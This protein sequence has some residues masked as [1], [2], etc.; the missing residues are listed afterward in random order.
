MSYLVLARK[1]RPQNFEDVSGQSHITRTLQN[2]IRAGRIAHAYLFTGVRGVGKTTAARI[3]AKAL[4]CAQGPTPTPCNECVQCKEIIRGN[5]IDV[6]EID[7]ASNRGI[8]EVRQIIENVRYQPAR[9]SFKIYII[10]EVHQVTKDAFNALLKTLEE[11]PASVKFILATT[12]PHRLPETILSRCQRFDF[13]RISLKEIVQR[14]SDISAS[15]GLKISQEALIAVAREADGSMRD[16]QSLL[17]QV[18]SCFGTEQEATEVDE[19]LLQ[20]VLGLAE[21]RMLF[22]IS[23]S[24]IAGDGRRCLELLAHA[25]EQGRDLTRLS[26]DLV[27]HFRNLMVARLCGQKKPNNVADQERA[28][29]LDLPDQEVIALGSQAANVS[30]DTLLDYFEVMAAGEDEV[31]RSANP[32]FNLETLLVRLAMLPKTLPVS[33]LIDRLT[34]L[35]NQLIGE[36]K[37]TPVGM[38]T[39]APRNAGNVGPNPVEATAVPVSASAMSQDKEQV[40]RTFVSFVGKEKKLLASHLESGSA[41]AIAPESLT[42]G[43]AEKHHLSYLQDIENMTLLRSFAKRFFSREMTIQL[44]QLDAGQAKSQQVPPASGEA[45]SEMV[46]EALRIF[47]G[48]IK[49]VRT[50]N[51]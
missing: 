24:I 8:E 25:A 10:D 27:E 16:A 49:G 42:I 31:A 1:W 28:E 4:N 11:P 19:T 50:D 33:Q 44:T 22:D 12:E 30:I 23:E 26:K 2:A 43:I 39:V 45:G 7:G 34:Q 51:S 20:E 13:R 37:A 17:E 35:E 41:V 15:E 29:L 46:K 38:K 18:L 14:L 21:R 48:S 5:C 36:G 47:G 9:C 32:R 3:L 40:W 6:I